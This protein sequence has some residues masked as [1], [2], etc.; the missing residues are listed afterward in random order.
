MKGKR[1]MKATPLLTM[2]AQQMLAAGMDL[3][4]GTRELRKAMIAAALQEH[5]GNACQTA[6]ALRMHR[7]TLSRQMEELGMWQ[8]ARECRADW[9]NQRLLRYGGTTAGR[10]KPQRPPAAESGDRSRVA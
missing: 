6:R 1:K 7:N 10:R 2:A 5:H 4:E 8:M 3:H 9:A